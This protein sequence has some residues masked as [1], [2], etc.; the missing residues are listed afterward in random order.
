MFP[1]SVLDGEKGGVAA[2]ITEH[3]EEFLVPISVCGR[4]HEEHDTEVVLNV[5][6]REPVIFLEQFDASTRCPVQALPIRML[7][8]PKSIPRLR[9]DGFRRHEPQQESSAEFEATH[10]FH[11]EQRLPTTCRHFETDMRNRFTRRGFAPNVFGHLVSDTRQ[12]AFPTQVFPC[13]ARV[14]RRLFSCSR[15]CLS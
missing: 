15:G 7:A 14:I 10:G 1:K 11:T 13:D 9:I 8:V 6:L 3:F 4:K 5:L 12:Y 2:A